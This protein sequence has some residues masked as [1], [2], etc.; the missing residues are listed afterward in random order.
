MNPEIRQNKAT[1]E[2]V[3]YSPSRGK[4]PKDFRQGR[5]EKKRPP[6]R[7]EDCPFCPGNEEKLSAIRMEMH[8]PSRC[9]WQTRVAPNR[10]PALLPE[11]DRGRLQRGIHLAMPGHGHH[12]VVVEH[13]LH[14]RDLAAMS[15]EE[16]GTVVETYHARYADLMKMDGNAMIVLFRNHGE[17]AGTSLVHPHSQIIATSLVPQHVRWRER[18]AQYYFDEW[19]RCVTCDILEFEM[20]DGRRL[21][22]D[23]ESFVA[24]VPFAAEVPFEIHIVPR[25][26]RA[27]FGS[28]SD[29]EKE[30]LSRILGRTLHVLSRALEDPDYNYVIQSAA[31]YRAGEP[32]L[33]W[34]LRIRPRLTTRAGFEIGSGMNINPS[35]PEEDASFLKDSQ[36]LSESSASHLP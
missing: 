8:G 29:E 10:F 11:G 33:H 5:Q 6:E 20:R 4:R 34:L 25:N 14:N 21:L 31:R 27:D 15:V 36:A 26:H 13:S 32:Q 7:E 17:R 19:G 23:N 30:D 1:K 28:V 3:I 24:F 18:E 2:W 9:G 35:I 12:E 16:V 22:F